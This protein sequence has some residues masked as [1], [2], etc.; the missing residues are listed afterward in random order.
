[1]KADSDWQAYVEPLSERLRGKA[2]KAK[3]LNYGD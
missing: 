3:D 1:L 2:V